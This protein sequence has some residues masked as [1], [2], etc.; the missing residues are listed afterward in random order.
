M[1]KGRQEDYFRLKLLASVS[2]M[3]P[4]ASAIADNRMKGGWGL[5]SRDQPGASHSLQIAP[6]TRPI[7]ESAGRAGCMAT[8]RG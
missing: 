3:L 7:N 6:D 4:A 2:T 8:T 1:T 5:G